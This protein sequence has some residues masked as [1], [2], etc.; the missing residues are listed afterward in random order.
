MRNIFTILAMG[1]IT[2]SLAQGTTPETKGEILTFKTMQG[3]YAKSLLNTHFDENGVF[4]YVK[5]EDAKKADGQKGGPRGAR[6]GVSS[7]DGEW[8]AVNEGSKLYVVQS[9]RSK[10]PN[11]M[12]LEEPGRREG[13][14]NSEGDIVWGQSVHRN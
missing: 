6:K 7:A 5:P 13:S 10:D 14:D 8:K 4:Q 9:G 3:V 2:S 1:I 12:T 11:I